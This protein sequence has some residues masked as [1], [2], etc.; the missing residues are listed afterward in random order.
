[1]ALHLN[2]LHEEIAAERQR[3]RDPLKIGMLVVATIGALLFMNYMWKGYQTLE[4][5]SRL[6]A[7]EREWAKV[8]PKVTAAQKRSTELNGIVRTTKVLDGL[9][10]GQ[11]G[12]AH[13]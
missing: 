4:M 1:M 10:D 2:L 6:T 5:K 13:V 8:E 9:I 7:V 11:I 3:Q 12:R